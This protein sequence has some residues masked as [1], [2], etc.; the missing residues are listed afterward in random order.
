M[1]DT[2]YPNGAALKIARQSRGM[3]YADVARKMAG[4]NKHWAKRLAR[5][6][7]MHERGILLMTEIDAEAYSKAINY[8]VDFFYTFFPVVY[9]PP[10]CKVSV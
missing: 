8:P 5:T 6:M 1:R 4:N 10:F 2:P 7:S 3:S 9:K